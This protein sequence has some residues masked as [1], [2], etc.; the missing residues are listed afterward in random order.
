MSSLTLEANVDA[1][2]DTGLIDPTTARHLRIIDAAPTLWLTPEARYFAGKDTV[3]GWMDARALAIYT[4]AGSV[5]PLLTD[6]GDG[7]RSI[8]F[9]GLA[10]QALIDAAGG[11][12][13]PPSG[14]PCSMLAVVKQTPA[15]NTF[16]NTIIGS[17]A[18]IANAPL[19]FYIDATTG[20]PNVQT[21]FA[22]G[23]QGVEAGAGVADGGWH[24]VMA[25]WK[26]SG[27][28]GRME[29]DGAPSGAATTNTLLLSNHASARKIALGG[30][31]PVGDD[32]RGRDRLGAAMILPL[33][34]SAAA[35]VD[36]RADVIAEM[37]A[38]R[39]LLAL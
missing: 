37:L 22:V 34:L 9:S 7:L 36:I 20:K 25:C 26:G 39:N 13:L 11:D 4:P 1:P 18:P 19:L 21:Q 31:G 32:V 12:V 17:R 15:A 3:S 5:P 35:N 8:K 38:W 30:G 2:V 28:G 29:I 27:P 23:G 33:D 6:E 14:S 10:G 24:L 16:G